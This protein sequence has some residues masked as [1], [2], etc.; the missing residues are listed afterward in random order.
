VLTAGFP[1]DSVGFA[2]QAVLRNELMKMPGVKKLSFG[3]GAPISGGWFTDLRTPE[4]TSK[5]PNL[6]VDFKM[7]DT[8]YFNLFNLQF[9]AGRPYYSSDTVREFVVNENVSRRLGYRD[10]QQAIGKLINVNGWKRPISGVVKDFHI[11]SLRDS[12]VPLVLTSYKRN[13]G[14]ASIELNLAQAKPVIAS[15][16]KLWDKYYPDFTFTYSFLDQDIAAYYKQETQLSQ[17]YQLFAV[18]AIF[19]SCLGLYGLVTFMAVQRRKEIGVRKVLGAPVSAILI[20]LSREFTLLVGIA[21]LIAAPIAWY[22]MYNWLQQYAY[23]VKLGPAIFA[24]TIIGSIMIAWTTVGYTAI[25]AA[26]ANP[27]KSLRDE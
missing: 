1:G 2:S 11:S 6:I 12:I 16:Q 20:L 21:F 8:S 13:Y 22:V 26:L 19:I 14:V 17:L 15:M 7:N 27:A 25:K 3:M 10:P 18:V 4:N 23:H 5:V 9:V 24:R